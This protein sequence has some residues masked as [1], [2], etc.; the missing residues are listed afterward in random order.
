MTQIEELKS[1]L[2]HPWENE[3]QAQNSPSH[4]SHVHYQFWE[5]EGEI[6]SAQWY[7]WNGEM[8]RERNHKLLDKGTHLELQTFRKD[9]T[10]EPSMLFTK[11]GEGGYCGRTDQDAKNSRGED[12]YSYVTV[13]AEEFTSIDKGMTWGKTPGPF[14]FKRKYI[15]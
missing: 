8:Y 12:V 2:F 6:H 5:E 3:Q 15:D 11:V 13:T 10:Q 7:D 9:G 14:I 1:L 4:F